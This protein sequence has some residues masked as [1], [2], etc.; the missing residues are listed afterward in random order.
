MA[1]L[2]DAGGRAAAVL[3]FLI[4]TACRTNEAVGAR[5]IEIDR[6]FPT[7]SVWKIPGARMKMDQD[8]CVPLTKPALD[9]LD[10]IAKGAQGELIFTNPDGQ[11]FSE[12]AM[13]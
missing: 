2:R 10:E 5:W 12:N 11:E 1:Q 13:L 7:G 9:I 4:F 6:T 3:R 8:H